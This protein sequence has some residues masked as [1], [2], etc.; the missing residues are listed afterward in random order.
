MQIDPQVLLALDWYLLLAS[1]AASVL[2]LVLLVFALGDLHLA[3]RNAMPDDPDVTAGWQGVLEQG[4]RMIILLSCCALT[5]SA[6]FIP[7]A[8]GPVLFWMLLLTI[9]LLIVNSFYSWYSRGKM[10]AQNTRLR[11]PCTECPWPDSPHRAKALAEREHRHAQHRPDPPPM[12]GSAKEHHTSDMAREQQTS[13]HIAT[14]DADVHIVVTPT[15]QAAQ[16]QDDKEK[17]K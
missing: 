5:I 11:D 2:S 3:M 1:F 15:E 13:T 9:H 4:T 8:I 14:P 7:V 10:L 17:G 16:R 12:W 6:L